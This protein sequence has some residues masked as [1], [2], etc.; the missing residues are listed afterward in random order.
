MHVS[1]SVSNSGAIFLD[2]ISISTSCAHFRGA[3]DLQHVAGVL[4]AAKG[5]QLQN[6]AASQRLV[7]D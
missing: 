5:G 2:L 7:G 3:P 1:S 4:P 6:G